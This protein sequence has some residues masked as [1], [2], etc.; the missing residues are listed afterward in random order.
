[1]SKWIRKGDQ[2]VVTAGN[3]KGNR[4]KVLAR[5]ANRIIIEGLNMRKKCI[6]RS[7]EH[8]QGRILDIE[9]AVHIS[10]VS[11]CDEDGKPIKVRLRMNKAGEREL[12]Y[13]SGDKDVLYR[14]VRK[15]K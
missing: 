4:G 10:N 1:M 14:A 7:E 15:T 2:V 6:R 11:A 12:Y 9:A 5:K 3:E 13:K 8:P